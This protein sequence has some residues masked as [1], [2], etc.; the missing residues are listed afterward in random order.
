[1]DMAFVFTV[2]DV[3]AAPVRIT[4]IATYNTGSVLRGVNIAFVGTAD[5][6]HTGNIVHNPGV[7]DNTAGCISARY[8]NLTLIVAVM[9]KSKVLTGAAM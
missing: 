6:I 5:Y 3:E 1:M 9:L 4:A 8:D 7:T 2:P